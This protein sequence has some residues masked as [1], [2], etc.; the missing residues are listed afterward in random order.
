MELKHFQMVCV[1]SSIAAL[2]LILELI[3]RRRIQDTLW[4]P[5]LAAAVTPAVV[6]LWISPWATT[7]HWLGVV[8]EPMVLVGFSAIISFGML[9]Y[10]SVVVSTLM[11]QN[12]RLAQEIA[13]LK[14]A[15]DEIALKLRDGPSR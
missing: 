15:L 7:A 6:G 13:L 12:L 9:L 5:W 14:H 1:I 3:R 10:L 11:R 8:Y 4:I 2:L